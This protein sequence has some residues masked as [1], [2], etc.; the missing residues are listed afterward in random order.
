MR[1]V[2]LFTTI[3]LSGSVELV[4]DMWEQE[5]S[6]RPATSTCGG[7]SSV[8]GQCALLL[9]NCCFYGP[10]KSILATNG[11]LFLTFFVSHLFVDESNKQAL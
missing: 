2:Q 8:R 4:C 10:A 9:R 1:T 11:V 3:I 7:G 5:H 6:T